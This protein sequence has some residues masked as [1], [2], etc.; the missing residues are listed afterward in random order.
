MTLLKVRFTE[1]NEFCKLHYGADEGFLINVTHRRSG[2]SESDIAWVAIP[3]YP[4]PI[5][6]EAHKLEIIWNE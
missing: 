4:L 3:N 6:I 1:N 5:S 2:Y